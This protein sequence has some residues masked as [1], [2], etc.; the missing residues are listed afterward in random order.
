VFAS[1]CSSEQKRDK[2]LYSAR[3]RNH[4]LL[5]LLLLRLDARTRLHHLLG[6]GV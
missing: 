4:R 3:D 6:E 5:Y 2:G 1:G